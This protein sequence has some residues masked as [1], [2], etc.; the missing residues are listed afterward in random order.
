MGSAEHAE[1]ATMSSRL[2]KSLKHLVSGV[3]TIPVSEPCLMLGKGGQPPLIYYNKH[4]FKIQGQ[5]QKFDLSLAA[6]MNER[7]SIGVTSEAA[8]RV[9]HPSPLN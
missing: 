1:A 5:D 4:G 6:V 7:I 2:N 3:M 9:G 8:T